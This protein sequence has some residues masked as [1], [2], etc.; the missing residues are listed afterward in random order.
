MGNFVQQTITKT[1]V[2]ELAAP[3]VDIATFNT[4]VS[5]VISGNPFL[6]RDRKEN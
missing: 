3:I 2:R 6:C 5:G 4:L 1:A